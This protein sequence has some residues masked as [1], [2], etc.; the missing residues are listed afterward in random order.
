M[1][2]Q[3]RRAEQVCKRGAQL[4]GD[5]LLQRERL[6][7]SQSTPTSRLPRAGRGFIHHLQPRPGLPLPKAAPPASST[8]RS[9]PQTQRPEKPPPACH[10]QISGGRSAVLAGNVVH[11]LDCLSVPLLRQQPSGRLGHTPR[12]TDHQA[13]ACPAPIGASL[14]FRAIYPPHTGAGIPQATNAAG[15]QG[16]G[17]ALCWPAGATQDLQEPPVLLGHLLRFADRKGT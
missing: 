11:Y 6:G 16:S 4:V 5:V 13:V 12:D 7:G 9:Q 8:S 1:L 15:G 3:V 17:G 14:L 2:P 10:L